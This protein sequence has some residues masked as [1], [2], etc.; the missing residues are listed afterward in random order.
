[1]ELSDCVHAV[2]G[3]FCRIKPAGILVAVFGALTLLCGLAALII[4]VLGIF[5]KGPAVN[6]AQRG[7]CGR[8]GLHICCI[9]LSVLASLTWT[10]FTGANGGYGNN[11]WMAGLSLQMCAI[12]RV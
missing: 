12:S 6:A 8:N 7:C 1:M 11:G 5:G 3:I 4:T 9:V 10:S 2:S